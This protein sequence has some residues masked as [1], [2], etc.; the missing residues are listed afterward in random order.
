MMT[1]KVEGMMCEGCVKRVVEGLKEAG[2]IAEVSLENKT[3]SFEGD[4]SVVK[5]A[6]SEIED[7]GF[8]VVK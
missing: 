7:L 6:T 5:K 2:I 4:E 1:M 3:V 8:E